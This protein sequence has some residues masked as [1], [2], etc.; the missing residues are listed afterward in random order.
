TSSPPRGNLDLPS[1]RHTAWLRSAS[2]HRLSNRLFLVVDPTVS[3]NSGRAAAPNDSRARHMGSSSLVYP[4]RA[5]IRSRP[6]TQ[7]NASPRTKGRLPLRS[8]RC[9]A[10]RLA[11]RFR[12]SDIAT[13][14]VALPERTGRAR[15]S[16]RTLAGQF[17]VG[18]QAECYCPNIKRS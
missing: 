16:G 17:S 7:Q 18:E 12:G 1:A 4:F 6:E 14:R 8:P 3:R 13:L 5:H 11:R 15:V 9:A 2:V 10:V